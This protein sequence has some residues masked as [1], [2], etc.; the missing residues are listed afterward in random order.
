[1]N[2]SEVLTSI[3]M[4]LGIYM[5]ALPFEN[6]DQALAD[7]IRLKTLRTFSTFQP[8]YERIRL[9]LHELERIEKT[10][11]YETYLL[12]DVFNGREILF[13]KDVTYDETF[14]VGTSYYGGLAVGGSIMKQNMLANAGSKMI[15]A[16]IPKMT[17]NFKHPRELTLYNITNSYKVIAEIGFKH[18]DSLASIPNTAW[19]SFMQLATLDIQKFLYATLKHYNDLSSAYATINLKID[20]WA[21]A[22]GDRRQLIEDWSNSYHLDIIDF[23]YA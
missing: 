8:V 14:L 4:D 20:D 2:L 3:K 23:T 17:F 11:S 18:D 13:I 1:M 10:A 12:P 22:D 5:I 7:V 21:N 9:D 6:A 15:S 19:D 16:M